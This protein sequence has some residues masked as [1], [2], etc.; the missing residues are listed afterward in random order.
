[1]Q[2]IRIW[3]PESDNDAKAVGCLANKLVAHLQL[4]NLSIRESGRQAVPKRSVSDASSNDKLRIAVQNYLRQEAC[5]IFVIDSDGP[6]S[7]HKRLQEPNSLINQ[8]TRI[9]E[10]P[11]FTGKVFLAQAV[12]ELEA[13][14][15][16]DCL[17]IFCYFA[18]KVSRYREIYRDTVSTK[19]DF[20]RL[21]GRYQKG[22]TETIVEVEMGGKGAKEYLIEFSEKILRTLNSRMP[23]RNVRNMRYSEIMSFAVAQHLLVDNQTLG[24]NNSLRK[25]CTLL[26]RFQ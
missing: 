3:T 26:A 17:G 2:T 18:R 21:V 10:D 25:L 12:Q 20:T 5:V 9:V 4:R 6:M 24:R 11:R 8:I 13:W 23:R 19:Q 22:N 16:I 14:L 1:M 15:L 7:S